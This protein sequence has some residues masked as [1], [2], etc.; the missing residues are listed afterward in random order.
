MN[1]TFCNCQE[2]RKGFTLLELLVVVGL[3]AILIGMVS[4]V[5]LGNRSDSTAFH[6]SRELLAA[7]LRE[8]QSF[9]LKNKQK[10]RLAIFYKYASASGEQ[11]INEATDQRVGKYCMAHLYD[12]DRQAW[13]PAGIEPLLLPKGIAVDFE[14]S[15]DDFLN[16]DDNG[17]ATW[18][19]KGSDFENAHVQGIWLILAFGKD[20]K[21]WKEEAI[22]EEDYYEVHFNL[23]EQRQILSYQFF[24]RLSPAEIP[25]EEKYFKSGLKEFEQF[26]RDFDNRYINSTTPNGAIYRETLTGSARWETEKKAFWRDW[27]AQ[28]DLFA[29][30]DHFTAPL[31]KKQLYLAFG[32]KEDGNYVTGCLKGAAAWKDITGN[33][34]TYYVDATS[35][36]QVLQW[37]DVTSNYLYRIVVDQT[38]MNR[39]TPKTDL[40]ELDF[41]AAIVEIYERKNEDESDMKFPVV[42]P[43]EFIF[44][45][46]ENPVFSSKEKLMEHLGSLFFYNSVPPVQGSPING[47]LLSFLDV[48]PI[49]PQTSH[50]PWI[51]ISWATALGTTA[52][53]PIKHYIEGG[54]NVRFGNLN[55]DPHRKLTDIKNAQGSSPLFSIALQPEDKSHE[56]AADTTLGFLVV[57]QGSLLYFGSETELSKLKSTLA[58]ADTNP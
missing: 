24:D 11:L 28:H 58:A 30:N 27:N 48:Y 13:I 45:A 35:K 7:K 38:I 15:R 49:N 6:L 26:Q 29:A 46:K 37:Y 21:T 54:T 47:N 22:L 44:P 56:E 4:F 23:Y 51:N 34:Y 16:D 36:L 18:P 8:V 3:M 9:A 53:S 14:K 12:E 52:A 57:P 43:S 39:P 17:W 20:G 10:A 33:I 19:E 2:T 32:G 31:K 40:Q 1:R 50:F 55:A 42:G 5:F 25:V 41:F